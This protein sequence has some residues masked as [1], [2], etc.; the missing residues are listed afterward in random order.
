MHDLALVPLLYVALLG[1]ATTSSSLL[2]VVIGLYCPLSKRVLACVLAFAAGTLISAL[3]IEL[4]F[5]SVQELHHL[6][7]STGAA[8]AFAG[9]GFALGATIYYWVSLF[10]E[11]KGA[12]VRYPTRFREYAREQKRRDSR[13]LI[14]LLSRCDLLRHLPPEEVENLLPYVRSRRLAAGDTLFRAGDPGDALYIVARGG[15]E[16]LAAPGAVPHETPRIAE[17]GE[18]SA[19]GE[20]ALLSGGP[21]TATV[22]AAGE[23]ET[24]LLAIEKRDF[25]HL[26]A[27]DPQLAEAVERLSHERAI[28]NLGAGGP[29]AATW[30]KVA[31]ASLDH[32]SRNEANRMLKE[33]GS[34]AG[35]AIVF[36]NILD[37]I[38]GC[39]VI[40][41][42]FTSIEEVSLTLALGMFIGGIPEAAA[43]AAILRRAGFRPNRIFWLW[44]TVLVAG[45]IAATAGKIFLASSMS[46]PA[47]FCEAVAGGAVLA[48]VAHAM[49]PEAIEDGGSLVVL[50]TVAGFLFAF[51]LSLV[52]T[53][54]P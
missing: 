19:F 28:T 50:P 15:V 42:K 31:T 8:W 47:L 2:G 43:S 53:F 14:G 16:I 12:A 23:T 41:A 44:S 51:Y 46:L 25:D 22:R 54:G 29:H 7:F 30:A 5:Q 35:L 39:L 33:T 36:G 48:L 37:T 13:E 38:P 21:R 24:E 20:M 1:L 6:G 34:G 40:G 18:G 9:G 45:V 49:I 32:L 11:S 4:A 17:L 52:E 3:A 27:T 26:M 10:L